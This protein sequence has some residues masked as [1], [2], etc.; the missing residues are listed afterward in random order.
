MKENQIILA[1]CSGLSQ[2]NI[3]ANKNAYNSLCKDSPFQ[4]IGRG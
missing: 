4:I 2:V 3:L 1:K